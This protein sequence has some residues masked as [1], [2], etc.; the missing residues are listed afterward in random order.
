MRRDGRQLNAKN[1]IISGHHVLETVFPVHRYKRHAVLV[2]KQEIA[3]PIKFQNDYEFKS[4]SAAA[5]V[6]KGHSVNGNEAWK[7]AEG[8]K[9]KEL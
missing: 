4:P 1:I 2:I 9:L 6:I 5:D 8:T 3:V 7:T